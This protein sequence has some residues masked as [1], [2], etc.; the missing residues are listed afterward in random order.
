[1][2]LDYRWAAPIR[3]DLTDEVCECGDNCAIKLFIE[4]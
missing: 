1:M 3:L 2:Q 4:I